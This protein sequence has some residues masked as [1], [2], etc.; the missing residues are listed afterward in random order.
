MKRRRV[1]KEPFCGFCS[2]SV[3]VFHS[4]AVV[5][6]LLVLLLSETFTVYESDKSLRRSSQIQ[7][8][9]ST[10]QQLES[11]GNKLAI[12]SIQPVSE[13]VKAVI[14]QPQ[15]TIRASRTPPSE[16][17]PSPHHE[18]G[19][20]HNQEMNEKSTN[21]KIDNA[22]EHIAEADAHDEAPMEETVPTLR[23]PQS[24]S[25][26]EKLEGERSADD[27]MTV[28]TGRNETSHPP[29]LPKKELGEIAQNKSHE[30]MGERKST[31]SKLLGDSVR[32]RVDQADA[33]VTG[34][35]T[36]KRS[37]MQGFRGVQGIESALT[38]NVAGRFDNLTRISYMMYRLIKTHHITSMIDIP[39][40][41]TLDWMPQLLHFLDFEIPEFR[42]TCVVP[43]VVQK[44]RAESAFG[45]QGSP[46]FLVAREYWRLQLPTTD[47]AFM[48][49]ILGFI[50]PQQSWALLKT[51][52]QAQT[53]YVVLPNYP[54][55]RN[56]PAAGTHHGRVNVRRAP[57]RF[58]EALRVFTN[59]STNDQITKQMLLYDTE[60]LRHDDL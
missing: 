16:D 14:V 45:D 33:Q 19:S 22:T 24:G 20:P 32:D 57:Y 51:I 23:T 31:S 44:K 52:R 36:P 8:S 7:V 60:R 13:N 30:V 41:N 2:T 39:C 48:W 9:S 42:Y 10:I 1:R 59:I 54:Q 55:L 58:A 40:T 50:T 11:P 28:D 38:A 15:D 3:N 49:N 21:K 4:A 27:P 46:E 47:V 12:G 53:K 56:N 29:P 17:H 6:V 25:T 35:E 43:S 5:S 37:G 18:Y 34:H 26:G